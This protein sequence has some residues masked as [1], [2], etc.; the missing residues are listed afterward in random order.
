MKGNA[1]IVAAVVAL[2]AVALILTLGG[3]DVARAQLT[4][5]AAEATITVDG[6]NSDWAAI[7]GLNVTLTQPDLSAY[8]DWT[9]PAPLAPVQ[10]V[11][12][13]AV[14]DSKIY[15]LLEI[16]DDYDFNGPVPPADHNLS[17]SP[18]VMFLIDPAAGPHMGAGDA[19]FAATL[20][21]VDLWH[22]ELDCDYNVMSGGGGPGSGNDPDCNLDDEF[23]TDPEFR[24]DDGGD[25]A[26]P[27]PNGENSIAG[28]WGHTG[29]AGGIGT[30]GTWIFEM[31]RLLQT[32]D[33]EDAQ[34]ADCGTASMA[35][36][37][38][39]ADEGALGWTD[40]GHLTSADEGFIVVTLPGA[41]AAAT[42]T[43]A[44]TQAATPAPTQAVL[45]AV[46]NTGGAPGAD[47]GGS[48]MVYAL[49]ALGGL[50]ALTGAAGI[51]LR[52]RKR[53]I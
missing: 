8:P 23:S 11:V 50:A 1:R 33:P 3:S 36:A 51:F 32:G 16:T 48:T 21:M 17:A 30:P 22:W 38:F 24:K 37:Y 39:D 13:V 49:L 7:G 14:D 47:G 34:F 9:A 2:A 43:P 26:N 20:G 19:D 28:R 25:V 40:T 15:V 27:N 10:S 46:P 31:S 52:Y 35:L 18:N 53:D 6:D 4:L 29:R 12:K 42:P 5:E 45:A 41:C 44:P